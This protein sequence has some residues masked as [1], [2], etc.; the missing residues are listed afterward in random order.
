V[1]LI[2]NILKTGFK[3]QGLKSVG[4]SKKNLWVIGR[5]VSVVKIT[6][7]ISTL[8]FPK[9]TYDQKNKCMI[10][11]FSINLDINEQWMLKI[12]FMYLKFELIV[13][14][15]IGVYLV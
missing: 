3:V 15:E 8:D 7:I 1:C 9:K 14:K 10:Y 4:G 11:I 6:D 12:V 2:K 5:D 13:P